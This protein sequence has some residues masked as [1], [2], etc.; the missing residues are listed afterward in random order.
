MEENNNK[1]TNT[2]FEEGNKF[3]R[4]I[5]TYGGAIIGGVVALILCFTRIYAILLYLVLIG[6]GAFVGNYIQY[7]KENV[8][9][10]L[11]EFIDK[12]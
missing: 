8:K 12:V 5:K 1:N 3:T 10:K 2:N 7:N 6:A 4:L 11:K 9:I